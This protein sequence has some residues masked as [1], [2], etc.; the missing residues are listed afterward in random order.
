M[1]NSNRTSASKLLPALHHALSG[2]AGTLI[3]TCTSYPLS[4]VVTRL[5]RQLARTGHLAAADEY[6]GIVDAFSRIWR[7]GEPSASAAG[8]RQSIAALYTGLTTESAKS[9][10]DSFLFFLFYEFFR[11]RLL[12]R[13]PARKSGGARRVI[14]DL[15]VGVAAG[16]CSRAFTTPISNVVTRKQTGAMVEG[17][18]ADAR[19]LSVR[20]I[21]NSILKEKGVKGLWSGYSA[22][23]VLTLN[24][25]ITFFLQDFLKRSILG[26]DSPE[27]PGAALTFLLAA[28]SKAI[29][30]TITYPFQ[31]AKARLQAGV[32]V[33]AE[34]REGENKEEQTDRPTELQSPDRALDKEIDAKL[35]AT[36]AVQKFAQQSVFGTIAQIVRTE[37]VGSL[38]GGIH[39]E[40]LKGFFSHGTTMLAKDVMHK[41]LFKLYLVVA[42]VL[43]E[44]RARRLRRV[45]DGSAADMPTSLSFR[46]PGPHN[47]AIAPTPVKSQSGSLNFLSRLYPFATKADTARQPQSSANIVLNFQDRTHRTVDED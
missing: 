18:N 22:T 1:T 33:T 32:P 15:A 4:L 27:D 9:V 29:A 3:S 30:S 31:T 16:A 21:V 24:P 25:G 2:S 7:D 11:S 34:S 8:T 37:G 26:D 35:K 39:G 20:E 41:L 44:L 46:S 12:S 19:Q 38:Y 6:A 28:S 47:A 43:Q 13:T 14:E 45:G 23:L 36:R 42:G 5:Q 17:E 10:L 40:L